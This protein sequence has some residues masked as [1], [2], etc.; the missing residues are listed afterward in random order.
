[1]TRE[2]LP[3]AR[4]ALA[5]IVGG[6]DRVTCHTCHG[7]DADA[8]EWRMPAVAA[9]PLPDVTT[10]GWETFGGQMDAQMR[11]AIY[12]YVAESD[13]QAKAAYM[14][15]VILPGMAA[16]LHRPPYDFTRPYDYN[17]SHLAFG[18]YHCHRVK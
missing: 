9:L 10:R 11:N 5:P 3:W 2:V 18:C 8:N 14:R 13:N 17:R 6:A 15:E 7:A 12:G 16:L 1:M 4:T